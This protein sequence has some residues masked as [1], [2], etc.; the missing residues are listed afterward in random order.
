MISFTTT[1]ELKRTRLNEYQGRTTRYVEF[2]A[3]GKNGAEL[4]ELPAH[5]DLNG[6]L[7]EMGAKVGL[8][9]HSYPWEQARV[10]ERTGNA[11]IQRTEKRRIV[12]VYDVAMGPAS[13]V[14]IP[15]FADEL[16][17]AA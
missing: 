12:G 2:T 9:V 5:G 14:V 17:A 7:P 15:E 3:P 11:Y 4:Y 10:S 6:E 8:I 16:R 13:A 1:V